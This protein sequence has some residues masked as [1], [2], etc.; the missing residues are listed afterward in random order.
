MK[1]KAGCLV[2]VLPARFGHYI[3]L[4]KSEMEEDYVGREI[5]WDLSPLPDAAHDYGGP[6]SERYIE[7][8]S[9]GG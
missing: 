5:Y 2:Q 7:V 1:I 6:M 9:E 8:V 4:G 3:V